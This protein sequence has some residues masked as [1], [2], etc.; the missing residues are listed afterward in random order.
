MDAQGL[1]PDTIKGLRGSMRM[2]QP[3]FAAHLGVHVMT[4][5]KWEAGIHEPVGE[6]RR[7]IEKMMKQ[8]RRKEQRY[9]GT[10]DAALRDNE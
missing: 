7:R 10:A 3:E 4:V 6:K 9:G 1:T 2:S 5:W 8:T